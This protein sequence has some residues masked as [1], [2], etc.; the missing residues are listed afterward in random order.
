MWEKLKFLAV[1]PNQENQNYTAYLFSRKTQ[2]ILPLDID[3]QAVDS[4][5][6]TTNNIVLPQPQIHDVFRE[7]LLELG[8][9]VV[10]VKIESFEDNVFDTN[11]EIQDK[12]AKHTIRLK[13]ADGINIG[14]RFNAPILIKNDVMRKCG[15]F[16]S[17]ELLHEALV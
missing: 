4:L 3:I 13:I 2:H 1:V 16:V 10:G 5:M 14:L 15:I 7:T 11:L 12:N 17:K 6:L 8:A 9:N